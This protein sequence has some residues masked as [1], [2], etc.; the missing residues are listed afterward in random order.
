MEEEITDGS[1]SPRI[2]GIIFCKE[3]SK[4]LLSTLLSSEGLTVVAKVSQQTDDT[5]LRYPPSQTKQICDHVTLNCKLSLMQIACEGISVKI[6][7]PKSR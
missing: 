2:R 4:V 1:L 5:V 6:S 7:A 3:D